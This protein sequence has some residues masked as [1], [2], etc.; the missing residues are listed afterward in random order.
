V[1]SN[2]NKKQE[3]KNKIKRKENKRVARKLV[4]LTIYVQFMTIN[5]LNEI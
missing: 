3:N 1:K 5:S 4:S 2:I